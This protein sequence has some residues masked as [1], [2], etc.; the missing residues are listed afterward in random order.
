MSLIMN[1]KGERVEAASLLNDQEL[2]Q[3]EFLT[4]AAAHQYGYNID[5]L[6]Y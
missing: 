4:N 2:S 1:A 3:A 6:V 5:V